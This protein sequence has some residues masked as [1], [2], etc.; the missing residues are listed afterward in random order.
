MELFL[1]RFK[2]LSRVDERL[3]QHTRR[4]GDL[5]TLIVQALGQVDLTTIPLI[6]ADNP[7]QMISSTT[8]RLPIE[9]HDSLKRAAGARRVSMYTLLN[10]AVWAYTE[11]HRPA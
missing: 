11:A 1:F 9:L 4:R 7:N 8:V 2:L 6:E 3:R 10:S 5:Q